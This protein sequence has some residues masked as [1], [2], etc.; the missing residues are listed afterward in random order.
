[1]SM[2]NGLRGS[3]QDFKDNLC[4]APILSLPDRAEYFI[5]YYDASN[6]GL[7]CVLMQRGKKYLADANLHVPVEEIKVDKT[8]HFVEEPVEIIDLEVKILKRSRVPIV[9]VH[10]NSK[11]GQ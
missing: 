3:L 11:R 6:Q 10:W 2:A 5:V 1:M 9:K 7:G 4:N 8:L